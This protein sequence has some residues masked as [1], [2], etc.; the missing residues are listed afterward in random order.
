M[1]SALRLAVAAAFVAAP[2]CSTNA[3]PP[4]RP[5]TQLRSS[6]SAPV[7]SEPEA[8]VPTEP[9]A[10]A[11]SAPAAVPPEEP[12]VPSEAPAPAPYQRAIPEPELPPTAPV[13]VA[14]NLSPKACRTELARK[15]LPVKRVRRATSGVAT[16]VRIDGPLHGVRFVGPGK[17]SPY[18]VLDCRLL[19][20]LDEMAKTLEPLGVAGV[21]VDNFHRPHAHLPG[22][23]ARSQHAYGL[24]ADIRGFVLADGTSLDVEQ[25]WHGAVGE[26]ACG[27]DSRVSDPS[28]K[29][30][31]LRNI[32]CEVVRA[33]VFHHVLTPGF[34]S[35][36]R[37]HLHLDIKRGDVRLIV[38]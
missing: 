22:K 10:K 11:P 5:A 16:P 14:A 28:P 15:K 26:T 34:N 32:V 29:A 37:N 9:V 27:P 6:E 23:K 13:S 24:A 21:V 31:A 1:Q 38:H 12:A 3:R 4:D 36:H 17:K 18:G 7:R 19:L 2:A 33:R 35:A 30:V 20:M 8:P 25:D